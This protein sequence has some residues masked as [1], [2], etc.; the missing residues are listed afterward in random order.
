MCS[1]VQRRWGRSAAL[2]LLLLLCFSSGMFTS[3]T[4][5]LPST[6]A[7]CA[8]CCNGLSAMR[9]I[10]CFGWHSDS[11]DV[12]NTPAAMLTVKTR[13]IRYALTA[14][15]AALLAGNQLAVIAAAVCGIMLGWVVAAV[16]F[17][18]HALWVLLATP[19]APAVCAAAGGTLAIGSLLVAADYWFYG[20]L[21]VRAADASPPEYVPL[22]SWTVQELPSFGK[23]VRPVLRMSLESI[24]AGVTVELCQV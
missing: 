17:L 20:R 14:G 3:S 19:L 1:G 11:S 13:V 23:S 8:P 6:F 5:F 16:A 24:C 21:T 22:N 10:A 7:M 4:T 2:R 18:P 12:I 9:S 15:T